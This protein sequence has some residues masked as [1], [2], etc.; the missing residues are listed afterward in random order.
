M[1]NEMPACA[2]ESAARPRPDQNVDVVEH[3][4]PDGSRTKP[5]NLANDG[6][7]GGPYSCLQSPVAGAAGAPPLPSV[8][9][10]QVGD[11][12]LDR[13]QRVLMIHVYVVEPFHLAA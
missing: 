4:A 12:P 10:T 7:V 1:I 9:C 3:D 11:I 8:C 5:G 13:T 6:H 2:D